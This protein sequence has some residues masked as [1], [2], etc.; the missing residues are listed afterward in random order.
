MAGY[1]HS[2]S[3]HKTE[4]ICVDRHAERGSGPSNANQVYLYPTEVKCSGLPCP[5][6]TA[7]RELPCVVCSPE[8]RTSAGQVYVRW[9]K[10]SCPSNGSTITLY[11]GRTAVSGTG[12]I[13]GGANPLCL[14]MQ[15]SFLPHNDNQQDSAFIYG[16]YYD[17][18]NGPAYSRRLRNVH[19]GRIPCSVCFTPELSGHVII[20]G[21]T[22]CPTTFRFEYFGY[23]FSSRYDSYSVNYV[24]VD[25]E[26]ETIGS[27]SGGG[28]A[29]STVEIECG[30]IRCQNEETGYVQD[31]E[32]TC[33]VCVPN[34]ERLTAFYTVW[35][36]NSC[37]G[38]NSSTKEVQH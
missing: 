34:T 7:N 9:G 1:Y 13:G 24:C 30:S 10:A 33:V 15:P 2:S 26:P 19:N 5:P 38:K 21:R 32:V 22:E 27:E 4:F 12:E 29:L 28:A 18:S 8:E 11:A 23:L 37:P 31:R 35:G 25:H 17:T 20:P 36:S 16:A 3:H 14:P 6:Y